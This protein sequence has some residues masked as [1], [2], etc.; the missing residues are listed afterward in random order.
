MFYMVW[1]KRFN[2]LADTLLDSYKLGFDLRGAHKGPVGGGISPEN[3]PHIAQ[4]RDI[5]FNVLYDR[6]GPH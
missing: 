3:Y 1:S 6:D 4:I 5:G 2:R